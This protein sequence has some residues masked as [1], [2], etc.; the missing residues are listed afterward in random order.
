MRRWELEAQEM[1]PRSLCPGAAHGTHKPRCAPAGM[2]RRYGRDDKRGKDKEKR[3]PGTD[4]KVATTKARRNPRRHDVSCPYARKCEEKSKES[5]LFCGRVAL[6]AYALDFRHDAKSVFAEDFADVGVGVALFQE[7]IGDLRE[8]GDILHPDGHDSAIEIGTEAN[9]IDASNFYGVINVLDDFG[10]IDFGEFAGLHEVA[11]DLIAGDKSAG[12][13]VATAFFDFIV[14]FFFG[15]GMSLFEVAE[16][17]GEKADVVVNLDN[18]TV[19][20]ESAHHVV[21]HV[22]GSLG[23]G[24]RGGVR[25]DNG[26]FGGGDDVGEGFVG[27]V[28]DIDHDAEA[29]H[30][31]DDL[32]AEVGEAVMRGGVGGRVSPVGIF[33]V[34]EGHVA[35]T[36]SGV[37]AE[38]G[39][40]VIDHVA[41]FDT[42]ERS[43]L[44][45]F[46]G[47]A[48]FFGGGGKD[49]IVGM[50]A[51]GFADG[52]DLVESLLNG[53]GA[54]D[55]AVDP[56][57]EEDGVQAAFA[58]ARDV[59]VAVGVT[60]ADIEGGVEEALGGVVVGIDNDGRGVERFGFVGD[61]LCRSGFDHKRKTEETG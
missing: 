44:A 4:L 49:K 10:P 19:F 52:V 36:E 28:R 1:L 29:I 9:V 57:G 53:D 42:H 61:G 26:S 41:A 58:H 56:D 46:F 20:C 24:A 60:R 54:G 43:D 7:R 40:V 32:L 12:F 31:E 2:R 47:G 50:F 35:N 15:F 22:A 55:F 38:D 11:D 45:L 30:F 37:G 39:E 5:R 3:N 25:S 17:L 33:H 34:G 16:F 48:D 23:D 14:D 8:M 27:D 51:N 59:D 21:G 6:V 18:A 13:I